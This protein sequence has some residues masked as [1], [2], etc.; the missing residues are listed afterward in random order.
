MLL[1]FGYTLDTPRDLFGYTSD[2]PSDL[3]GYT[4]DTTS[5]TTSDT[6]LDVLAPLC[7]WLQTKLFGYTNA[8][9]GCL[10]ALDPLH[11]TLQSF[12]AIRGFCCVL[13]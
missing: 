11:W 1:L 4:S 12:T 5:A 13:P 10:Q 3:F 8:S 2:T 9:F 7:I 6:T